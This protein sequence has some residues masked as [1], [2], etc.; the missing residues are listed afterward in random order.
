VAIRKVFIEEKEIK[1]TIQKVLEKVVSRAYANR[2][3]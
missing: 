2:L 1:V 3:E